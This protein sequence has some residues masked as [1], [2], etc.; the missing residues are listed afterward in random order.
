MAANVRQ[1][2]GS[3]IFNDARGSCFFVRSDENRLPVSLPVL[4]VGILNLGT[5]PASV[6][7]VA[8]CLSTG[9]KALDMNCR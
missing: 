6:G 1:L 7:A 9:C 5:T 2:F 3:R 4:G 8:G